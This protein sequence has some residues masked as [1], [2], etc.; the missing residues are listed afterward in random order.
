MT[1]IALNSCI[2]YNNADTKPYFFQI[3]IHN[4]RVILFTKKKKKRDDS[5]DN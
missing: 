2:L 1:L 3:F 4:Y 5:R